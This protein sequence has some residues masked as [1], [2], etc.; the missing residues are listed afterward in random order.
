MKEYIITTNFSVKDEVSGGSSKALENYTPYFNATVV[1]KLSDKGYKI[2]KKID[3]N[4]LG[5]VNDN[6]LLN[7]GKEL[8]DNINFAIM[9]DTYSNTVYEAN[10]NEVYGYKP[11]YGLISRF[12]LYQVSSS[13][14]T[15]SILANDI[16]TLKEVK[17]VVKGY[18]SLDMTSN[19]EEVESNIKEI[20]Y[21][22]ELYD[23]LTDKTEFDKL[24]TK[25]NI[26]DISINEETLNII[27]PIHQ[28]IVSAE[29]ISSFASYTSVTIDPRG[30]G[31]SFEEIVTNYRSNN[32]GDDLKKQLVLGS[33]ILDSKN[34]EKYLIRAKKGR[35]YLTQEFNKILKDKI[36]IFPNINDL[37][38]YKDVLLIANLGG[39]PI[40]TTKDFTS[41]GNIKED[42]NLFNLV[43]EIL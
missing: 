34:Y 16:D 15:V 22:K 4:E 14:D 3:I 23:N 26:K 9:S 1:N 10:T 21:I 33:Y 31:D 5:V 37:N 29:S 27:K 39:Y 6:I 40:I 35:T 28:T 42:N 30:E 11:T 13:L 8:T 20:V 18:D 25:F 32:F 17:D 2:N 12:G 43:K 24:I 38:K 36:I 7:I 19:I 41:M